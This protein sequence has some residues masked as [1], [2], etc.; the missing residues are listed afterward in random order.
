MKAN[1]HSGFFF[2]LA[3]LVLAFVSKIATIQK[4]YKLNEE[5]LMGAL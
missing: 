5:Y 4:V 1:N 2:F 3:S